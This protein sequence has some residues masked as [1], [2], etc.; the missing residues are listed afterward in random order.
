MGRALEDPNRISVDEAA[1]MLGMTRESLCECV[2]QDLLPHSIGVAILKP[3][4][5]NYTYYLYRRKVECLCQFWG[6]TD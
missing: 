5:K 3:G 1:R 6:L 2:K 4:H